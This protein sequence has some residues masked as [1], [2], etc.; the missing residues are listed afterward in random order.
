MV[1]LNRFFG[2]RSIFFVFEGTFFLPAFDAVARWEIK[3]S[4][5][6]AAERQT[7][8]FLRLTSWRKSL[9][10]PS[11]LLLSIFNFPAGENGCLNTGADKART[12]AAKTG[13]GN[14]CEPLEN[15][16]LLRTL[17]N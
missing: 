8:F 14:D 3:V 5:H 10:C 16:C 2:D 12:V 17:R 7:I 4:A 6:G 13:L 11:W 9:I 1:E 15:N